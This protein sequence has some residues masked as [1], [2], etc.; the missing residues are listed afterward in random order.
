VALG[1]NVG[2][3]E[4]FLRQARREL[5]ATVAVRVAAASPVFE[6]D[7]VGPSRRRFLN[8]VLRLETTLAARDLWWRLRAIER[9][10]GRRRSGSPEGPN[11]GPRWGP[12]TLDLDLLLYGSE[13]IRTP[14]LEVPHPR[15][16]ERDFVLVPLAAVSPEV[17]HPLLSR[18]AREM[19]DALPPAARGGIWERT[20]VWEHPGVW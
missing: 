1:S 19:L 7:P 4:G 12:R 9:G 13:R 16:H 11:A 5:D 8:A 2:H 6:T 17:R 15:L 14:D 18:T 10:A 3:R 20:D